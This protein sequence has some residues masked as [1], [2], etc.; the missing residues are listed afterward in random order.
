MKPCA[1]RPR[2]RRSSAGSHWVCCLFQPLSYS[3]GAAF[4]NRGTTPILRPKRRPSRRRCLCRPGRTRTLNR[5]FWRRVLCQL[6]YWPSRVRCLSAS[7]LPYFALAWCARS[8]PELFGRPAGWLATDPHGYL[9]SR[10][11]LWVRHRGQ[12]FLSSNR[13]GSFLRFFS[14]VYVRSLHSPH[15][16]VITGR[17]SFLFEAI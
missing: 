4:P 7:V 3:L 8:S 1:T 6:S 14:V 2:S 15:C 13:L 9:V 17:T 10:C 5:S 11:T 12:N 16:R